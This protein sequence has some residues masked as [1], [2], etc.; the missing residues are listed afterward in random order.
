MDKQLDART[1]STSTTWPQEI[2]CQTLEKLGG[3]SG[4]INATAICHKTLRN[5]DLRCNIVRMKWEGVYIDVPW[6]HVLFPS[7][8]SGIL[9]Y[10]QASKK[11][12]AKILYSNNAAIYSKS[13][14]CLQLKATPK[15]QFLSLH[16]CTYGL[17]QLKDSTS[18]RDPSNSTPSTPATAPATAATAQWNL[19][20]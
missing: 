12:L 4:S 9:V 16:H 19:R 6:L 8:L 5:A 18:S 3:L 10:L 1:I 13:F 14:K 11:T 2:K 15:L 7:I 20:G 17:L